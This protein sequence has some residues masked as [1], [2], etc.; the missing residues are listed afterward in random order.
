MS[1]VD[2]VRVEPKW[3]KDTS[4]KKVADKIKTTKMGKRAQACRETAQSDKAK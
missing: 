1:I 4:K 3:P 2:K